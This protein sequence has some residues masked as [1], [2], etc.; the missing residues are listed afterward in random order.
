MKEA[1]I[2]IADDHPLMRKGLKDI[3]EG[4]SEWKIVGEAGDGESALELIEKLKPT[5]AVIDIDM[6]KLNGLE[7]VKII[8]QKKIPVKIIILTMYDKETIFNRA[9]DLGVRGYVIKD[10]AV[11]EVVEALKNVISGKYYISPVFSD[12]LLKRGHFTPEDNSVE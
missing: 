8:N 2:I 10:S 9:M 5:A 12:F 1:T 3:I 7:V 11:T 4:G 6:P